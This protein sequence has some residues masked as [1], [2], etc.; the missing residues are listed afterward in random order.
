MPDIAETGSNAMPAWDPGSA[1]AIT[2]PALQEVA[3]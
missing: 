1:Y 3:P 2:R